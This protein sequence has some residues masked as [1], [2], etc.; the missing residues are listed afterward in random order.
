M[1]TDKTDTNRHS[2]RSKPEGVSRT[3]ATTRSGNP[4][5]LGGLA[6]GISS[7]ITVFLLLLA[8]T[9]WGTE[10]FVATNGDDSR[11]GTGGWGDALLTISNAVAKAVNPGDVVTV[12][13]GT[14]NI[15][16]EISVSAAITIRSFGRGEGQAPD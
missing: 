12:S 5:R 14:Y 10:Y 8:G 16:N 3:G 9:T 7:L 15:T 13:N 6:R 11:D 4:W 2:D 1:R